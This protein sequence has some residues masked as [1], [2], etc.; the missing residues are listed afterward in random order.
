MLGVLG[1]G[2]AT[3]IVRIDDLAVLHIA[4]LACGNLVPDEFVKP[5]YTDA[6]LADVGVM[7]VAADVV[8][9]IPV[10]EDANAGKLA[11]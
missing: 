9:K 10:V 1:L 3:E 4:A 5:G 6:C 8:E 7:V 11:V 2:A